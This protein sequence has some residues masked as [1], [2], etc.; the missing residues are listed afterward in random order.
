MIKVE[1]I[2]KIIDVFND[3]SSFDFGQYSDKSFNRRIEKIL[4]DEKYSIDGL[5]KK[6][7]N[8]SSYLNYIKNKI[9][10]NTT[11]L[12]RDSEMWISLAKPIK[13]YIKN[14]NRLNIWHAGVSSGEEIYSMRIYLDG[15]GYTGNAF[16]IGTD[17]SDVILESAKKAIYKNNIIAN[18]IDNYNLVKDGL[19]KSENFKDIK[20]YI[21][22]NDK[23]N[24]LEIKP[25]YKKNIDFQ[26]LNLISTDYNFDKKFDIIM[27]RNVLI[28]FSLDLQ[29]KIIDRFH[30]LLNHNGLLVLGAHESI[31]PPLSNKFDNNNNIYIKL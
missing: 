4:M 22:N 13:K 28:Y 19:S 25:E 26:I 20:N 30:K 29:N 6:I 23:T 3:N 11:E 16:S 14:K 7:S 24:L 1:D 15:I 10:V 21:I 8:D 5:V 17:I 27:C 2:Q 12:F 18:Y 9:T 31:M